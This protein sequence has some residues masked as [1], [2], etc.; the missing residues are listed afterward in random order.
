MQA[1][2]I[3]ICGAG[4][5]G[6]PLAKSLAAQGHQVVATKRAIHQANQI[7]Q[8]NLVGLPFTLGEDLDAL[9]LSPLFNCHTLVLNIPA[10]RKCEDL[11]LYKQQMQQLI[12]SAKQK[13][14]SKLVF[15][16]STS[17]YGNQTGNI[18]EYSPLYP[19][20]A[21][22][23]VNAELEST[24]HQIFGDSACVLRLA[25]LVGEARHPVNYLSGKRQVLNANQCVNLIHQNDA[26][27]AIKQIIEQ[28][29]FGF[30]LHLAAP[31]HPTRSEYYTWAAEQLEMEP[32]KFI[33]DP[34]DN[35]G[36]QI[37]C[38]LTLEKLGL[39]LE[40]A[41]PYKMLANTKLSN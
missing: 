31:A 3:A 38:Q 4:W 24:A 36:K 27:A 23:K 10:S 29:I 34:S 2:K 17:V 40:F 41:S 14:I 7:N 5:L 39:Q 25:G 6:L 28:D 15:V 32:P 8:H 22:A 1:I 9:H 20:T 13:G 30:N 26:V 12:A 37:N 18:Y 16:S 35:I 19:S 21:S 11:S 33:E